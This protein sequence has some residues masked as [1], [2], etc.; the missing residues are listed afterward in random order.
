MKS[1][2]KMTVVN[3]ILGAAVILLTTACGKIPK[4]YQGDFVDA[5]SGATLKLESNE[6]TLKTAD[7][8][9][10]KGKAEDQDFGALLE[11]KPAIYLSSL[12]GNNVDVFWLVPNMSTRQ[13]AAG[14]VWY[15]SEVIYTQMNAKQDSQVPSISFFRCTDGHVMLDK[16]TKEMTLGCPAGP[17]IMNM[18]RAGEKKA[19]ATGDSQNIQRL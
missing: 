2:T 5:A 9:E 4:G 7:G 19:Q 18:V 14:Y 15:T 6:G 10:L 11:G 8:R 12:Q 13:E 1:R 3:L 16:S 17:Q